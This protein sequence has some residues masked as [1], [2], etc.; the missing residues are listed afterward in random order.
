[1]NATKLESLY[2]Q[3]SELIFKLEEIETQI[4]EITSTCD[5]ADRVCSVIQANGNY[6]CISCSKSILLKK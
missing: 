3:K 6:D 5:Y 2:I 1:M 4:L